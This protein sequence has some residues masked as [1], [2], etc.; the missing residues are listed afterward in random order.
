MKIEVIPVEVTKIDVI[1]ID[2]ISIDVIKID[3]IKIDVI[4]LN[5]IGYKA[6]NCKGLSLTLQLVSKCACNILSCSFCCV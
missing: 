4:K 6:Q 5:F 2:V 1:K 3:V